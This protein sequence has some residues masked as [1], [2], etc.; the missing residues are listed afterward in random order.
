MSP[1]LQEKVALVGELLKSFP[2]AASAVDQLL[3]LT[4]GR[5]CF[6]RVTER[7]GAERVAEQVAQLRLMDKIDGPV[8]VTPPVVAA[9]MA[10][11]SSRTWLS[12]IRASIGTN[13]K[14]ACV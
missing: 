10:D 7:I 4:I 1:S 12:P 2:K 8:G 5:M 6:E 3:G 14:R 9:V 13:T 11:A